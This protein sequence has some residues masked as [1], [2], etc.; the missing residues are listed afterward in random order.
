MKVLHFSALDGQ[1]GAGVAAARIHN[2]LVERGINSRFCVAYPSARLANAFTPPVTLAGSIAQGLRQRISTRLLAPHARGYDYVLSTGIPGNDIRR[3]VAAEQPDVIHLHWI[4]GDAFRL[5]TLAG[6]SVPIVW[7]LSDMWP[8]CGLA[9]LEPDSSQY[10][11]PPAQDA[12]WPLTSAGL[13]ERVRRRKQRVYGTLPSL[14][15]AVP[16]RWLRGE[17]S[18]SALLGDRPI[19]LIPTSCDTRVFTPRD[20]RAC[21]EALGL[22]LDAK[23]V[24]VGA[25]SMGTRWKGGDLFVEAMMRLAGKAK[26]SGLRIVTFG[27][28]PMD[29]PALAAEIAID[30]IGLVRDRQLMTILYNAADVFVAPSRMENLANTVLESLACGTPVAAFDIGGMPDMIDHE[31][32]GCIAPPFDTAKLAEGIAWTLN[33]AGND[34]V[35]QAARHKILSEFSLEQEID[36]YMA[37]Y[38]KVLRAR[39]SQVARTEPVRAV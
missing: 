27:K 25:T 19:E 1:T 36:K 16:S 4:N 31:V 17:T 33:Q 15:L 38:G 28:D 24:L 30:H 2:G 14:T 8:F 7:R 13:P 37:L 39:S 35:R 12:G 34:S 3:I 21:R 11:H 32:N 26:Q 5:A 29:A 10:T 18:R 9:H 6:I 22:P 20:R 23:I